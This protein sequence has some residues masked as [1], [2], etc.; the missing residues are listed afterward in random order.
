LGFLPLVYKRGTDMAVFFGSKTVHKVKTYENDAANANAQL[1]IQLPYLMSVSRFAHYLKVIMRDK[2]GSFASQNQVDAYLNNWVS[3]YVI[4]DD[5]AAQVIKA[6]YPLRE[7]RVDVVTVPGKVGSYKAVMF[8]RPHFY[9]NDLS[10]SMRL[11][12]DLPAKK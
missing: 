3:Q 5:N 12:T 11:V 6:R 8:L 7:A 1:T 4:L 10:I 9:L 2:I